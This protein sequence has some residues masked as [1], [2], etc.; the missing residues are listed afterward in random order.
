MLITVVTV[1]VSYCCC[2]LMSLRLLPV[3]VMSAAVVVR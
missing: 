2:Q 3:E 1:E